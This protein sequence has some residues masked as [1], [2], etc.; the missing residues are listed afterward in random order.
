MEEHKMPFGWKAVL[1]ETKNK[2][3][4]LEPRLLPSGHYRFTL[5]LWSVDGT[6]LKAE[7]HGFRINKNCTTILPPVSSAPNG[8]MFHIIDLSPS[9]M[10]D[11]LDNLRPQ[12]RSQGVEARSAP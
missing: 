12:L 7:I 3:G 4:E 10:K 9:G 8:H 6:D 11:L 5:E 2:Y 1:D